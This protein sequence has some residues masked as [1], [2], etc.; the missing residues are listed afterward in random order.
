MYTYITCAYAYVNTYKY[1]KSLQSCP[2]LCEPMARSLPSSSVHGI[3][4]VRI[5]EWVAMPF[6]R[7]S[8]WPMDQTLIF[9]G[10][11]TAGG[12]FFTT[13]P[14]EKSQYPYTLYTYVCVYICIYTHVYN[15][16][17]CVYIYVFIRRSM[18]A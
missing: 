14:P 9:C 5:L 3:L 7:G 17:V 2:T 10:S 12:F 8:S 4:Q 1:D 18:Y 16:C 6:S 11:C 15:V 13:E